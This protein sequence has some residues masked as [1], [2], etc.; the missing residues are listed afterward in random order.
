MDA[1]LEQPRIYTETAEKKTENRQKI[2][3]NLSL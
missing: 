1:E 3:L 2:H